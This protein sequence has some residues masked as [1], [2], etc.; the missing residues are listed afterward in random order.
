MNWFN[1][2]FADRLKSLTQSWLKGNNGALTKYLVVNRYLCV[3]FMKDSFKPFLNLLELKPGVK[4][5]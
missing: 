2:L 5:T 3:C 4:I 1:L